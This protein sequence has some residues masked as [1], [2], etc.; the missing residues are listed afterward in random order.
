MPRRGENIYKR[1]DGRWEGRF[2]ESYN[3]NGKAKYHS[4]YAPSYAEVK[5]KLSYFRKQSGYS[6]V[7]SSKLAKVTM[8]ILSAISVIFIYASKKA[9]CVFF[10]MM[11]INFFRN[12][13]WR[14]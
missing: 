8:Q 5:R 14:I 7:R 9:K 1:K 3:V 12:I 6:P 11:S 2:L 4:V 10:L 13:F